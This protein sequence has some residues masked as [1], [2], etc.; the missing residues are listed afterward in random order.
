M[1]VRISK[2]RCGGN[3]I[4]MRLCGPAGPAVI[5]YGGNPDCWSPSGKEHGGINKIDR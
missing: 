5:M 4:P 3:V 2:C 1:L